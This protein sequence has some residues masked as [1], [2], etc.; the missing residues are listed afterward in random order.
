MVGDA[1]RRELFGRLGADAVDL[2]HRQRPDAQ[3]ECR[4][5][6][7][8]VRPSGFSRSEQIFDSSL[9]G[10]TP[11]EQDRP[12]ASCTACLMRR[13]SVQGVVGQ[14]GQV[15]VDLVDAAILDLRRNGRH[16]SLEQA[17]VMA[18]GV[19]IDRQQDRVR[20]QLRRL[21]DAHAGEHAERPRFVGGG[22]D[23]AAPDIVAQ[24][25]EATAAVAPA[26]PAGGR[27]RPPMT[28]GRPRSSG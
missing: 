9:L 21:H 28:T 4:S 19:E 18:I 1:Q 22:G 16:G 5:A 25:G 8:R 13:A 6:S 17:R 3:R 2:A 11:I 20:R 26:V 10:V 12:V 23:D 27:W 14:I 15:D 7:S 24:P